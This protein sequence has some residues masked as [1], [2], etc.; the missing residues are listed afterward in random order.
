[1]DRPELHVLGA[2]LDN[3]I[4][5]AKQRRDASRLSAQLIEFAINNCE[6]AVSRQLDGFVEHVPE[7]VPNPKGF[8]GYQKYDKEGFVDAYTNLKPIRELLCLLREYK[9]T[10]DTHRELTQSN[11]VLLVERKELLELKAELTA[12]LAALQP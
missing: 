11:Y 4:E 8:I 3:A 10:I 1:M 7:P 12:Q 9:T 6:N 2:E 5:E